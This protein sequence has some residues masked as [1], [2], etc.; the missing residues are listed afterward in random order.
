MTYNCCIS[1]SFP[2][3]TSTRYMMPV[4]LAV[5]AAVMVANWNPVVVS[6]TV[7]VYR[8]SEC[9]DDTAWFEALRSAGYQVEVHET[10][11]MQGL[12]QYAEVPD[13]LA[14]C[15]TANA[16]GYVLEGNV[17]PEAVTKLLSERPDIKGLAV[18]ADAGHETR[19]RSATYDVVS[20][21]GGSAHDIFM[22]MDDS[23]R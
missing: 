20:I 1:G 14:A 17:P 5:A 16:A 3:Q 18:P 12:R 2:V 19:Q 22:R 11:N 6:A 8:S 4:I 21:E 7:T 15:H 9:P 13:D 10:E 23:S